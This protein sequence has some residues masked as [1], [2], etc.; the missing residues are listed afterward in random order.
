[1]G[2]IVLD[3]WANGER[4]LC[5]W[6]QGGRIKKLVA[7]NWSLYGLQEILNGNDLRLKIN[8]SS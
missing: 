8:P 2:L 1:M 6:T 4:I 7:F 5:E 3:E